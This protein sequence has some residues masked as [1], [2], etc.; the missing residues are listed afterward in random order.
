[1]NGPHQAEA[2]VFDLHRNSTHDGPGIRTTVFLKGCPLRCRWCHNPESQRVSK[3]IWWTSQTCIGCYTCIQNCKKEALSASEAGIAVDRSRCDGCQA[4]A[5][6]CPPRAM[7]PLGTRR[8]LDELLAEVELDRPWYEATGGGITLSG[9]EPCAQ[10]GFATQFL[11]GCQERDL[12]TA[13][14]TCGQVAPP[15]FNRIL[16]HANLV[17]FDLKH[18]DPT[19]HRELTGADLSTIHANLR[20]AARRVRSGNLKLW[21]R[22]PL[23][24]GATAQPTALS[25]IGRFLRD[26]FEGTVERWELCAFNPSCST[27]YHRLGM[28]WPYEDSGLQSEDQTA[29][30]LAAAQGA[31]GQNDLVRLKGIRAKSPSPLKNRRSN[32]R[33]GLEGDRSIR[34]FAP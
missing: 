3:E 32:P 24:P 13:L 33:S 4:C 1:M 26:E 22:T 20:E 28:T 34:D 6:A 16:D 15:V 7:R 30:L 27:K 23:V 19:V 9:G 31:C 17:L 21:V 12:H 2:L 5:D 10:P 8:P 25:A 29:K 18:M 11:K 14:D